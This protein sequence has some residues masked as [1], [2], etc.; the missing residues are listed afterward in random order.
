MEDYNDEKGD[1]PIM[2][3]KERL[4][5]VNNISLPV[6]L[7]LRLTDL[8]CPYGGGTVVEQESSQR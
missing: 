5:R 1:Q 8:H 7:Y 6:V 2:K 4:S 3:S